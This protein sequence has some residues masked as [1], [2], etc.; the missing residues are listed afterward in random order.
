MAQHALTFQHSYR[1]TSHEQQKCAT[2]HRQR[3]W[4]ITLFQKLK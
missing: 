3:I 1:D 4:K 2:S